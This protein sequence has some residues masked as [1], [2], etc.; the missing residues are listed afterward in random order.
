M[1][2]FSAFYFVRKNLLIA[3]GVCFTLSLVVAWIVFGNARSSHSQMNQVDTDPLVA[4]LPASEAVASESSRRV[5][6][7]VAPMDANYRRDKPGKSPMGMDLVAVYDNANAELSVGDIQINSAVINNLGV[8]T[9][10]VTRQLLQPQIQAFGV[11]SHDEDSRVQITVRSQGWIEN[12]SVFDEGEMVT[13]GD[14]LFEL[15]SP[16]LL[17]AQDN[18]LSAKAA[19]DSRLIRGALGRMRSLAIPESRILALEELPKKSPL[20]D[21]FRTLDY[22]AS[23]SGHVSLLGVREGSFVTPS[24]IALEIVSIENVWLIADVFER[25]LSRIK[26]G[27]RASMQSLAFPGRD[28]HGQVEYLYPMLDMT[29]RSQRVR[30]RFENPDR[31]LKPNMFASVNIETA[32]FKAL[33]VPLESVIKVKG[34]SRVV[35]ALGEGRF[36]SVTVETGWQVGDRQVILAGLTVGDRVVISGQFLLD[37]ESN[38]AAGFSRM[39]SLK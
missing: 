26:M 5:L 37:S 11:I 25:H 32:A 9:A 1:L 18:F 23:R 17:H 19:E 10:P 38:L 8:R 2:N 4:G 16:E 20:P 39:E 30:L 7:W 22:R 31:Q 27:Q 28:W 14:L 24:T 34:E 13:K 29:T 21:H 35:L 3:L 36:R 33:S 6:Y 15:Y 12:L